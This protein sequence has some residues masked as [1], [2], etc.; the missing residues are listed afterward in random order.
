M[1]AFEA[2]KHYMDILQ[3]QL[4]L[5]IIIYDECRLLQST[6]L[7]EL[8]AVGKWHTNPYCLR[9]KENDRL[10]NRCVVLKPYFVERVLQGEGVVR[11]TCYCGVTEYAMPVRI[12]GRLACIAS[13]TGFCGTLRSGTAERLGRRVGMRGEELTEMRRCVLRDDCDAGA[14]IGSIEL[15]GHLIERVLNERT[16]IPQRMQAMQQASNAHVQRA[17]EYISHHFTEPLDADAVAR[18]C[19][20]NTSYLQHLF[21]EIVGHGI[22]EEIRLCRLSYAEELLCTT[23]YSV[24][25]VAHLTGFSSPDYFSTAFKKQFGTSP[26][27]YKKRYRRQGADQTPPEVR[28]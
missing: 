8:S 18:Y 15:L 9:I 23:D 12:G 27:G 16:D 25:Y 19:H 7:G 4:G 13:A 26:R 2:L 1:D 6:C 24:R 28:S 17:L 11:S 21:S 14:V 5:D 22:A 3:D 10:R 20:V